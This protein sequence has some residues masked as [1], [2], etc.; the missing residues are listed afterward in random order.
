M[1]FVQAQFSLKYEP[2]MKIRR[3]ANQIE[4]LLKEHYGVPQVMPIPDDFAAEAP[5]V[6]FTSHKAHSQISFSQISVD[7][8]V[9]FDGEY[10]NNFELTKSYIQK[11]V[12]LLKQVLNDIGIKE[13]YFFGL[14][15]N[16][17]LD[18]GKD[19]PL[20]YI[21]TL[22]G[23]NLS[24]EENLYEVLQRVA[25][26]EEKKFFVNQQVSTFRE[27]QNSG[28]NIP[29]LL[30]FSNSKL[31]SEGVSISLDINNRYSFLYKGTN[32]K[33]QEFDVEFEKI[34][35]LMEQNFKKWE[36]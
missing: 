24:K 5:R 12:Y 19:K 10:R 15:Y 13:Y 6:V 17:R 27:Y 28:K 23:D 25:L 16:A 21:K 11:R 2:H 29:N 33:M 30:D 31:I 20:E 9:N 4:D 8:T 34:Y 7:L 36:R 18:I 3:N 26:V 22:L 14:T 35:S 1:E 32:T